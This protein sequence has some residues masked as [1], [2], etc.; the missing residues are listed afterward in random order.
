MRNI[1][2]IMYSD[3]E[4]NFFSTEGLNVLSL[5]WVTCHIYLHWVTVSESWKD[6]TELIFY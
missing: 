2:F 3:L 1:V 6:K 4:V 5:I